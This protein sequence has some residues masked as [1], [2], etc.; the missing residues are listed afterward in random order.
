[1]G[2]LSQPAG[3]IEPSGL[4][5][6]L[7][8]FEAEVLGAQLP[9]APLG[10]GPPRPPFLGRLRALRTARRSRSISPPAP[11]AFLVHS[12]RHFAGA[13]FAARAPFAPTSEPAPPV[14]VCLFFG[15]VC[16][17]ATELG[18]CECDR[19]GTRGARGIVDRR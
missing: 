11:M 4:L 13:L 7:A 17:L 3:P 8:K 16:S 10:P 19:A 14:A 9:P 6:I 2:Q 1:M 12:I 5:V 15:H 18:Q